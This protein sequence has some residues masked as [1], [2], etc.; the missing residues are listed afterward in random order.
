MS[1]SRLEKFLYALYSLDSSDLPNPLS[2]IEELYKC[3]VTGDEAPTFEPISRVEK[4][5]MA[6]LGGYDVELLPNPLSRVE[7]LLYKLATGDDNLDDIKSFLSEHEELLAEIIRNGGV[8]GNIDIE[9][10]LYTLSTEFNTLYNTA[11]K[12]VKSAILKGDT[13]VNLFDGEKMALNESHHYTYSNGIIKSAGDGQPWA[14]KT[15]MSSAIKP[16]TKYLLKVKNIGEYSLNVQIRTDLST[17]LHHQAVSV[18]QEVIKIIETGEKID[19]LYVKVYPQVIDNSLLAQAKLNIIEYQDGIENW[20]IPY[21]EGMQSVK[22]PVLTTVGKNLFDINGKI[23]TSGVTYSINGNSLTITGNW[24]AH[25]NVDL[26]PNTTYTLS[27]EKAESD[28]GYVKLAAYTDGISKSIN[29][30]NTNKLTFTTPASFKDISVLFYAEKGGNTNTVTYTNIQLEEG[31]LATSYEPHKTN[32]LTV[33]EDVELRGIGDVQDTLD[34]MTGELTERIGEVVLDGSEDETWVFWNSRVADV[35]GFYLDNTIDDAFAE[36]QLVLCD[37][38]PSTETVIT[39]IN[40]ENICISETKRVNL[41]ISITK[42]TSVNELRNYLSQNPITVQYQLATESVKTVDLSVADQDGN[43]TK[44]STFNDITHVTLSSEGLIPEAELEV[45]TKNEEDLEDSVVYTIH[46]LSEEFN[47]LYNTAEKQVKSAILKGNTLVNLVNDV[48]SNEVGNYNNSPCK[49]NVIRNLQNETL[50]IIFNVTSL[51]IPDGADGILRIGG[52]WS[53]QIRHNPTLGVNK[54]LYNYN[55]TSNSW[56][57]VFSNSE[58]YNLGQR[59]TISDVMVLEGDYTNIDI[60][61]F[62]GMQSVKMP[63]LKTTGKNLINVPDTDK[64]VQPID[65]TNV[66]KMN[67]TYTLTYHMVNYSPYE[68]RTRI[69]VYNIDGTMTYYGPTTLP[70]TIKTMTHTFSHTKPF[71]KVTVVPLQ[72]FGVNVPGA[73]VS[74]IQLEEGSVA[75]PYEP[76][77]SNILTVNEEVELRGIGEV[78][79]ELNLITGELTQRVGTLYLANEYEAIDFDLSKGST[80]FISLGVKADEIIDYSPIL[81]NTFETKNVFNLDEEGILY[82][83]W[84][85][86]ARVLKSR[87]TELTNDSIVQYLK[88]I[89][90][91]VFYRK[92][93]ESVK[94]VDLSVVDQ[95][96]N[97]TKLSTFDDI[98]HVTLSSEGLIPEAE[99]EVVEKVPEVATNMFAISREQ[100]VINTTANEQSEN[101]DATMIATTE[102]YEELL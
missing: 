95:D 24:F 58:A 68:A 49:I 32:I 65:I 87:I 93:V 48:T 47:T 99:L 38:L 81:S 77:K 5:L 8:G 6:I 31:L 29:S 50:T 90:S 3:L 33:N 102:I 62:E 17:L 44:L 56:L 98:T 43:D 84:G 36:K 75:T 40:K 52:G 7:V 59:I 66:F 19:G 46:T 101:T 71:Y 80:V 54:V 73:S 83:G 69:D 35:T 41:N 22:M 64:V 27:Y 100:E 14:S 78:Q 13:L 23:I 34:L 61:Y 4:Y 16:M 97:N 42:A 55:Q 82:D 28:S 94:T 37:C 39:N 15:N 85:L 57:G 51:E 25:Q 63:V 1:K 70:N 76:Y 45:A 91:M 12:P 20:D 2:R 89:Q 11:E 74:Q 86:Y 53:G 72:F 92:K 9:Y 88:A 18:G 79:D 10:V 30:S 60:P 26:K 96:G 21:F 67:T